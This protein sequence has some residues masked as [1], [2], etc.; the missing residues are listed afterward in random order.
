MARIFRGHPFVYVPGRDRVALARARDG[1]RVRQRHRLRG[2]QG[3]ARGA[4]Q[5]HR[6][7]R[8]P[9]LLRLHVP[10]PPVLRRPA[11]RATSC[12]STTAASPSSTSASTSGCRP[13]SPSSSSR[14]PGWASPA[15]RAA[16]RAPPRRRLHRRARALHARADPAAVR[17]RDLVVHAR[18]RGR[19]DA[20]DRDPDRDRHERPAL[21][22]L[23]RRCATRTCRPTTSS[24]G[25]PRRS[26]S[27]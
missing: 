10:P 26:R 1:H 16:A 14:S 19:A 9:L 25:A 11:P 2:A 15:G 5:P 21:A 24:G 8:L 18:R 27:P 4:A 12:C 13:S 6:R 20:R 3:L 22:P 23:R 7:D 17:G